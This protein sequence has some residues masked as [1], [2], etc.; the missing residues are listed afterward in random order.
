[1]CCLSCIRPK[2]IPLPASGPFF[3]SLSIKFNYSDGQGRQNGRIHWRFDD[4][5]SKML[6]FTPL[7]QV[8]LELNVNGEASLLVRPGKKLYWRGDF[9]EL[10]RRLWGIDLTLQELKDL[11]QK[12]Q[13]PEEKARD[14][15]IEMSVRA[16]P[17]T[18]AVQSVHIRQ[19]GVT[20]DL[21]VL[22][23]ET[24]PGNIVLLDY[25][26]RFESAEL[27]DVLADD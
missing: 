24:R 6:F 15:G 21:K 9:S 17:R 8:G 14:Q 2:T 27:E 16:N 18:Q 7:N 25:D 19:D 11:L 12:G 4:Q 22:K 1:M 20:L 5:S 3:Q 23:S 10:L 13:V 26:R